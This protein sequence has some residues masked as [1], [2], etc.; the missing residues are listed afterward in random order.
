MFKIEYSIISSQ[1]ITGYE[2]G[3]ISFVVGEK[4]I[5][6][7]N[8]S[9]QAF[10]IF[11]TISDLLN[12]IVDFIQNNLSYTEIIGTDS[13]F[14]IIFRRK[15][16][17]LQLIVNNKL[18]VQDDITLIFEEIYKS[19]YQFCEKYL[20]VLDDLNPVKIDLLTAFSNIL[21]FLNLT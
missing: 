17:F 3:F 14:S 11:L 2:L 9:K 20:N 8:D 21:N 7:E 4:K 18:I 13:S 15:K 5:K 16:E 1:K 19:S 6:Y 12:A 10:M